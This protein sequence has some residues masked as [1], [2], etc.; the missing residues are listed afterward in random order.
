MDCGGEA[1]SGAAR[2]VVS[3]FCL[4][5]RQAAFLV[6]LRWE[7]RYLGWVN[8]RLHPLQHIADMGVAKLFVE[9]GCMAGQVL[10]AEYAK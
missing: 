2:F 8:V 5:A 10:T 7:S 4:I 1:G 3:K 6:W 9:C